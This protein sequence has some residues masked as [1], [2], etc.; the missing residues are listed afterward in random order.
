MMGRGRKRP[1]DWVTT[2]QTYDAFPSRYTITQTG[3]RIN[4]SLTS[5]Q[6]FAEAGGVTPLFAARS[7][8]Q[9]EQTV[10]RVK[11]E[12][13]LCIENDP[14]WWENANGFAM[15]THRIRVAD[16]VPGTIDIQE[17]DLTNLTPA[18]MGNATFAQEHFLWEHRHIWYSS[19]SWGEQQVAYASQP[20]KIPVDVTTKRR[21]EPGQSLALM[22]EVVLIPDGQSQ[23][24][25]WPDMFEFLTLRTL[26]R[27][28]T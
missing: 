16:Q 13:H 27:T 10:V 15:V 11:G 12:I 20:V 8:P 28:I 21:L 23:P 3:E 9:L 18:N 22:T 4:W 6:D 2:G 1:L 25:T 24:G 5:H 26:M 14:S 7:F 19:T 17:P